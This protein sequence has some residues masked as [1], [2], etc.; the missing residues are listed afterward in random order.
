MTFNQHHKKCFWIKSPTLPLNVLLGQNASVDEILTSKVNVN[1][2]T[3]GLDMLKV[4]CI[5]SCS[6]NPTYV[7][8]I[9][10]IVCC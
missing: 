3:I 8:K 2:Q 6:V 10:Q 7:I 4:L 1:R 5:E 9:N